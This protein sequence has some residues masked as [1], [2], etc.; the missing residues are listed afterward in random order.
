[1]PLLA[2][3]TAAVQR[4][5]ARRPYADLVADVRGGPPRWSAFAVPAVD[6]LLNTTEYF[7][8]HED[9]RRAQPGGSRASCPTRCRTGCGRP[10]RA[11]R[12]SRSAADFGVVLARP[13]GET[14]IASSGDPVAVLTG[15][16]PELLLY[17]FG[18]RDHARVELTGPQATLRCLAG[19]ALDV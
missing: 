10:S 3:H 9:V 5:A 2:G 11:G 7:V 6:K 18:R 13:D 14:V 8:H 17:L 12:G 4:S 19:T 1:M 16:P 15:E